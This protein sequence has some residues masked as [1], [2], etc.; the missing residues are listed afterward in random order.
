MRKGKATGKR[1]K[2]FLL[3]FI[4]TLLLALS[5][6]ISIEKI[7][8]KKKPGWSVMYL[9]SGKFMKALSLGNTN[10]LADLIYIW[11]IQYYGNYSI[12][13]RFEYLDKI[14]EVITDL[15]PTWQDP[16]ILGA[17]IMAYEGKRVDLALKLL[18]KGLKVN[19]EKWIFA[20][21]AGF[22]CLSLLRDYSCSAKYF[23]IAMETPG[24]PNFVKR[25][26]ANSLF[27]RG[28]LI[29]S[30]KAWEE[31]YNTT[32][33]KYIK[34]V[35]Y[36]HLYEVK[37]EIDRRIIERTR[38]EWERRK[39]RKLSSL[40]ALVRD[41]YLKSIPKDIDGNEYLFDP[42]KRTIYST[43]IRWKRR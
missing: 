10:L 26:Y 1:E 15:N 25:L 33:D 27:R 36:N 17:L 11:A 18:E 35:A 22:Y 16:Y 19:P 4:L 20:W 12:E 6:Q 9:P 37:L 5:T 21:E 14:F 8:R 7:P 3:L 34:R 13:E 28:D 30:F 32:E 23:K 39:G 2:I 42:E 38:D 24:S 41:G 43:K 40:T 29:S 31:I